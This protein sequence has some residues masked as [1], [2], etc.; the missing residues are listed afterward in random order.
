M[1]N[2]N[3]SQLLVISLKVMYILLYVHN[4]HEN[5]DVTNYVIGDRCTFMLRILYTDHVDSLT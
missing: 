1:K 3:K 4:G 2:Y 5:L